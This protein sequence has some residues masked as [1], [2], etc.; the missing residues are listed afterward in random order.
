MFLVDCHCDTL[1]EL[2]KQNKSLYAN[3]LMLDAARIIKNGG[4]LQFMA[5]FIP[6]EVFRAGAGATYTLKLIDTYLRGLKELESKGIRAHRILKKEDLAQLPNGQFNTLL[7]IEEGGA[8]DGSIEVLRVYYELGVRCMT[9]VW[10]NRNDIADGVNEE[11]SKSGLTQF[12]R[13]VVAEMNRLGMA[14]DVSHISTY[15]FWDVLEHSTK[16]IIATHSCAYS[17]CDHP[18][19]LRDDQLKALAKTGGFV[20]INFAGQFLEKDWNDACIES[21]YRHLAYMM[22][23]MGCDDYLGFGSDFDGI[24]HPPYNLRG[25]QDFVPL[26]DLLS[27]KFSDETIRKLAYRNGI[28]YLEKVL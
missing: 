18:R 17:L 27:K 26:F 16:P 13:Q 21:V 25:V 5:M 22:D 2:Y 9:L 6:T 3:D 10:S 19:N 14:V 28:A 15:G 1:S 4:G 23:V 8:L 20:G 12:G 11:C 7:A 24:S